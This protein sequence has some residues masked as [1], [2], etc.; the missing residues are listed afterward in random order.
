M[1]RCREADA[2]LREESDRLRL[3][4]RRDVELDE[5]GLG[6]V[7]IDRKPGLG[8]TEGQP[9]RA[10]VVVGEPVDVVVERVDARGGDDPGLAHRAAEEVLEAPRVRHHLGLPGE[11]RR[12]AGSRAPSRGRA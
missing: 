6:A 11:E 7:R 2:L 5:V 12:R 3:R 8:Q 4:Q 1:D 10:R 9:L